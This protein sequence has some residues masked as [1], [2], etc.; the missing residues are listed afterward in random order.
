MD[1]MTAGSSGAWLS[2]CKEGENVGKCVWGGYFFLSQGNMKE[3]G[4]KPQAHPP[5]IVQHLSWREMGLH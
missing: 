5:N 4:W 1:V 3:L 2:C